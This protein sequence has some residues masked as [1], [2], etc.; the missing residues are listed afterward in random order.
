MAVHFEV[1]TGNAVSI[2][3]QLENYLSTKDPHSLMVLGFYW[4]G[5]N[6]HVLVRY[7]DATFA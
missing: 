5:A 6:Y 4:D 3:T 1:L 7:R 2:A